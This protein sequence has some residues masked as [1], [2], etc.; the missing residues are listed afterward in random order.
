LFKQLP[1]V[2]MLVAGVV[3]KSTQIG[4]KM[5]V[6]L[7]DAL[8]PPDDRWPDRLMPLSAHIQPT[9]SVN[10]QELNIPMANMEKVLWYAQK[11]KA[12]HLKS[13]IWPIKID[14]IFNSIK[15]DQLTEITDMPT[16]NKAAPNAAKHSA[17]Q[18][19][20]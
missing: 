4:D 6:F 19:Q 15:T 16:P 1:F 8:L 10:W 18:Q 2:V 3:G 13:S 20:K 14:F 17:A 11:I 5:I 9:N 7:Q 12:G